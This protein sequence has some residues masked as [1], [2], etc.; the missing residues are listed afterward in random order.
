[1]RTKVN[2]DLLQL[3]ADSD[4]YPNL[5]TLFTS[6]DQAITTNMDDNLRHRARPEI[7]L[8]INNQVIA[9]GLTFPYETNTGKSREFEKNAVRKPQKGP[10]HSNVKF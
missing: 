1:M 3:Y 9:L 7:V 6:Y 2:N 10:H 5:A 4:G 8:R